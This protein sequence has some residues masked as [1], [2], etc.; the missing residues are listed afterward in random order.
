MRALRRRSIVLPVLAA[1]LA[2]GAGTAATAAA[3]ASAS[4]AS[5]VSSPW[6]QTDF[7][8]AHSRANLSEQTLTRATLPHVRY[9]RS[10]VTPLDNRANQVCTFNAMVAPLLT[11]GSL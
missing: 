3:A 5:T 7:N 1:A 4:S 10:V 11:G 8:S 2:G 6:S 9:L